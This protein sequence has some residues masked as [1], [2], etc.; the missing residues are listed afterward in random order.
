ME[1][2]RPTRIEDNFESD[3][4][5][6]EPDH[7]S[8][9]SQWIPIQVDDHD[10]ATTIAEDDL[11]VVWTRTSGIVLTQ[12]DE[13]VITDHR[14]LTDKHINFARIIHQQFSV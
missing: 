5:G 3:A 14:C 2:Q 7:A 8:K 11:D 4:K 12:R 6:S 1:V 10:S 13:K 9:Y